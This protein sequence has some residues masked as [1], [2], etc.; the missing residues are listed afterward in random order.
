MSP[1]LTG[2]IA[3]GISGNLT[4][5]WSPEGGYDAL[6]S[7]SLSTATTSI[8]FSG[9]PSTY[10]HLQIRANIGKAPTGNNQLILLYFNGSNTTNTYK[11]H[12]LWGDGST[13]TS[14]D[15]N[16]YSPTNGSGALGLR[17][18]NTVNV[19]TGVVAD[20]LDYSNVNKNT[21][22]R[23]FWGFD[24]NGN[25]NA[26]P[27]YG[28][29]GLTSTLWMNTSAVTSLTIEGFNS[30]NFPQHSSFAIYGVK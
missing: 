8:T 30:N 13:A 5:P 23:S 2:V 15:F 20:V 29:V 9:I 3:S 18:D 26:V 11:V 19:F 25:P 4:P 28:Q 14:N 21:T 12:H 6:A 16:N 10:K 7:V 1:I 24:T 22:V 27:Q 17:A